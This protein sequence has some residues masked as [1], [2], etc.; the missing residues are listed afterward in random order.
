[1]T[2]CPCGYE[3]RQW[4]RL[5][6][7][8]SSVFSFQRYNTASPRVPT[9]RRLPVT[10]VTAIDVS[11][12]G[13]LLVAAGT[14]NRWVIVDPT[15]GAYVD[16]YVHGAVIN[17]VDLDETTDAM[18]IG[19]A[20]ATGTDSMSVRYFTDISS[21]S[22]AL[23][24]SK[25]TGASSLEVAGVAVD[26]SGNAYALR[27]A[28][29][30]SNS[31][32]KWNAAGT[33]QWDVAGPT[34]LV[35]GRAMHID[36]SNGTLWIFYQ[37]SGPTFKVSE[38]DVS[39]GSLLSTYTISGMTSTNGFQDSFHAFNGSLAVGGVYTSTS[40]VEL[41]DASDGSVTWSAS[42]S[43]STA[44]SVWIKDDG[45]VISHRQQSPSG[46]GT[47]VQILAAATGA[48]VEAFTPT[49]STA[50]VFPCCRDDDSDNI[51]LGHYETA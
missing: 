46:S 51:Y 5:G 50:G 3:F 48:E 47:Q 43:A 13:S 28:Y 27:R 29:D 22:R 11:R 7:A 8:I 19:G 15:S 33:Q 24:W 1:M 2:C 14:G 35:T 31:I 26:S 44:V 32:T 34:G 49:G 23:S 17:A 12:D 25:D 30:S 45:D 38:V 4:S 16:Q 41:I 18:V 10:A 40:K 6:A 36:R 9:L 37:T 42:L 20:R 21:T 39:D